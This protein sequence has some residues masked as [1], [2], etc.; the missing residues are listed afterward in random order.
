MSELGKRDPQGYYVIPADKKAIE[1]VK[2]LPNVLI[3]DI[4]EV[5]LIKTKSRSTAM[6]ILRKLKHK[7]YLRI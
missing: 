4:G 2:N 5:L 3:E 1:Y 7:G 6:K